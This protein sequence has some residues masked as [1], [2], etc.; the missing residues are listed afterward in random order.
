MH[1]MREV[2]VT[3]GAG[4]IGTQLAL[5]FKAHH[6]AARVVALDNLKRRGSELNLP[7]LVAGDVE[8]LHGDVRAPQDLPAFKELDLIIEC[9][10]E[11]SVLAG[12][13]G[14]PSYVIESNLVGAIN[15]LELARK[16]GAALIFLSTSRVYPIEMLCAIDLHEMDTRFTVA[17]DQAIPGITEAGIDETF[18]I[19]GARSLYGAT[20]YAAELFIQ[21]YAAMYGLRAV[22]N[23]CGVIAGPWQMGRVDQGI[24]ALWVARHLFDG[25]LSYIGFGGKGKQVRDMLHVQDLLNLVLV[26]ASRLDT[27]H[28]DIFNV[29]GG[30]EN[31]V[32]LLELTELCR[33]ITGCTIPVA[34]D[35]EDR[36]ADIPWYVTNNEHVM[37]AFG[38]AP[39]RSLETIVDD[40]ARWIRDHRDTL[41]PLLGA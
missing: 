2:L 28:A 5:A 15:C 14:A 21:E 23:R 29:G 33:N 18:P 41:R 6:P 34:A 7:R 20:K 32:S 36:P 31:S 30:L 35:K 11:P 24:M 22:I 19:T 25:A 4:F 3:G 40:T 38:W 26:Q 9:S 1:D 10:A 13:G 37:N 27:L 17:P 16:N 8:F 12:Y 39:N